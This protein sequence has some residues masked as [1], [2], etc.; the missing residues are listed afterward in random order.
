[1]QEQDLPTFEAKINY[2]ENDLLSC[3]DYSQDQ[4]RDL[5]HKISYVKSEKKMVKSKQKARQILK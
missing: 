4:K 2:L 5:K 3:E 1:M